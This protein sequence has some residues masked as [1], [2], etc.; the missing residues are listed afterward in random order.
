MSEFQ[1]TASTPSFPGPPNP[2]MG[3]PGPLPPDP[4]LSFP[5]PPDPRLSFPGPPDPML[6]RPAVAGPRQGLRSS[7]DACE[8][9]LHRYMKLQRRRRPEDPISEDR[10]RMQR[11]VVLADL[12]TLRSDI[13]VL[14]KAGESHRWGRWILGGFM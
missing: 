2:Q 1:P 10:L 12:R 4:K 6:S 9:S 11:D 13:S 14:V 5:P 3:F 7:R 8:H